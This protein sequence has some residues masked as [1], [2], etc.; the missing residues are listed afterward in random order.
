MHV[1]IRRD[2]PAQ[3]E[4]NQS[5]IIEISEIL[6]EYIFVY[7]VLQVT[8]LTQRCVHVRSLTRLDRLK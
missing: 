1:S 8:I 4:T 6:F 2:L 5:V 3:R 7:G